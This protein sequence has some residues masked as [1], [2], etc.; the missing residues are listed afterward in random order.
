MC[1]E[2]HCWN[3]FCL[4]E[5]MSRRTRNR[6]GALQESTRCVGVHALFN[7]SQFN[8][9]SHEK[10]LKKLTQEFEKVYLRYVCFTLDFVDNCTLCV[11]VLLGLCSLNIQDVN[12]QNFTLFIQ[13]SFIHLFLFILSTW[14]EAASR[15]RTRQNSQNSFR[16]RPARRADNF[17]AIYCRLS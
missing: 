9:T 2:K 12:F 17:A 16:V 5:N 7:N 11:L 15:Y 4:L 10:L 13:N 3:S 14:G 1:G 8:S 6:S